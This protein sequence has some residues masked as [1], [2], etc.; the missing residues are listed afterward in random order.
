MLCTGKVYYDLLEAREAAGIDDVYLLRVEQM[1]PFPAQSMLRELKRF[2]NA[3]VIWCQEEPKNQGAWFFMEPNLE[4]ALG[5]VEGKA[6][7]ARYV[8][9]KAAAAPATGLASRHVKEQ[10][11]LVAEALQA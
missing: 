10:E 4:W 8:G 11:A 6:Q 2:P 1:Y 7:R 5:R 3:D 9:R